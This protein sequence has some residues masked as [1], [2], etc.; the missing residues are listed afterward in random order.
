MGAI[1]QPTALARDEADFIVDDEADPEVPD[2]WPEVDVLREKIRQLI[3]K[4]EQLK[5]LVTHLSVLVIR[6][7]VDKRS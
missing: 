1:Q 2:V 5:A 4:N 6:N 3:K 7:A